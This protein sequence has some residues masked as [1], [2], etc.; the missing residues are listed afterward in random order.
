MSGI[1]ELYGMVGSWAAQVIILAY[2]ALFT[3]SWG[4]N[5][6]VSCPFTHFLAVALVRSRHCSSVSVET[7]GYISSQVLGFLYLS[8]SS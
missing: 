3:F 2:S 1:C 8:S 6:P 7:S 5:S 4:L